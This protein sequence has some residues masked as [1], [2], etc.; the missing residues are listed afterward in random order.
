MKHI[1]SLTTTLACLV[2]CQTTNQ[3][4]NSA[5]HQCEIATWKNFATAAV[6]YTF[7][8][9]LPN[10]FTIAAPMLEKYGFRGSFYPIVSTVD[11]WQVLQKCANEGHEIGSHTFTHLALSQ[12][13]ADSLE[14]ELSYSKELINQNISDSQCCTMVYPYCNMPDTAAVARHYIAAR[15]CDK[16][17]EPSTPN[18]YFAISS[19]GIGSESEYND[20]QSIIKIFDTAYNQGG[21]C[22][23]LLHEIEEG[24]GYSPYSTAALDSTM[25]YLASNQN[26]FWVGTFGD[27]VK[28][29][30]ERDNT[31]IELIAENDT[32]KTFSFTNNLSNIYN[33][34][35]SVR[36][37]LPQKW[38][39]AIAKQDQKEIETHINDGYIYF[40]VKPNGGN[41]TISKL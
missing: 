11:D 3:N 41:V 37:P 23:L 12:L 30:R 27:V 16:R 26:K 4:A 40:E 7:D 21:W 22:V 36:C 15:I 25:N 29:T 35:I 13:S 10:Q 19:F 32:E 38:T 31:K 24:F 2:A 39:N 18:N 9:N 5:N 8:D 14:Y 1:L 20:A 28:Y 6:S 34:A 17:I 33:I